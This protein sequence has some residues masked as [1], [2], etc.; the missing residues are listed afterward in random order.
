MVSHAWFAKLNL[1]HPNFPVI[2]T[3]QWSDQS[4]FNAFLLLHMYVPY[5][6]VR[7][8]VAIY[9]LIN[10]VE[11]LYSVHI[12]KFSLSGND[13]VVIAVVVIVVVAVLGC[14]IIMNCIFFYCCSKNEQ[15]KGMYV[16]TQQYMY[17]CM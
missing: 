8:Y 9:I 2:I 6:Q 1:S 3:N 12:C 16:T 4:G 5:L 17:G 11:L 13:G 10:A 15:D 14:C 7:T